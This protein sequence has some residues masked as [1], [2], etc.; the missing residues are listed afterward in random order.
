MAAQ[1]N[2][3]SQNRQSKL[4][5]RLLGV[6]LILGS[7]LVAG[8][9]IG[10]FAYVLSWPTVEAVIT[11]SYVTRGDDSDSERFSYAYVVNEKEYNGGYSR[12]SNSRLTAM[13]EGSTIKVSYN[14]SLPQISYYNSTPVLALIFVPLCCLL[15]FGLIIIGTTFLPDQSNLKI[16]NLG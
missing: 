16:N 10:W 9:N 3:K 12:S 14:P 13:A 8:G 2:K 4:G 15:P 5:G 7:L 6:A 1:P 11:D